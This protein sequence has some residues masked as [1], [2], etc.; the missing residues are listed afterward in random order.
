MKGKKKSKTVSHL[1]AMNRL[2]HEG[3]GTIATVLNNDDS[4]KALN[5]Q[6]V[7]ILGEL[8]ESFIG[9]GGNNIQSPPPFPVPKARWFGELS[10]DT[11]TPITKDGKKIYEYDHKSDFALNAEAFRDRVDEI[12]KYQRMENDLTNVD[13]SPN[14]G[15]VSGTHYKD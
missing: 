15:G 14:P 9:S 1:A 4:L 3:A 11:T 6:M 8:K 2:F 7:V 12:V 5:Q 13:R 10:S